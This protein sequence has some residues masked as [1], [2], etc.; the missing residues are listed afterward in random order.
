MRKEAEVRLL[1]F[2]GKTVGA[3]GKN[4]RKARESEANHCNFKASLL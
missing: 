2:F 1:L 3:F 4:A